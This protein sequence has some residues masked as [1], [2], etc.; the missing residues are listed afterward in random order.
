[1]QNHQTE[2]GSKITSLSLTGFLQQ[3][4]FGGSPPRVML[5]VKLHACRYS[6]MRLVNG[7]MSGF[8][9]QSKKLRHTFPRC[10]TF[11]DIVWCVLRTENFWASSPW[12]QHWLCS[13]CSSALIQVLVVPTGYMSYL[14]IW[15]PAFYNVGKPPTATDRN[16]EQGSLSVAVRVTV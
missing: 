11:A 3:V 12:I 4:C 9:S 10:F 2:W 15:Y 5:G 6:E 13:H 7:E 8:V 16:E 1:M 14:G